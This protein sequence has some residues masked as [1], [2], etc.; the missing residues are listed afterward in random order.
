MI[1]TGA[2]PSQLWGADGSHNHVHIKLEAKRVMELFM[3]MQ[4]ITIHGHFIFSGN[5][6]MQHAGAGVVRYRIHTLSHV[7][8]PSRT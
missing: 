1:L 3:E 6:Y 7:P 2:E 5:G 8:Q 4:L